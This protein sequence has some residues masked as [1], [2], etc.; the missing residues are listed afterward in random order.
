MGY[1]AIRHEFLEEALA[2]P[3]VLSEEEKAV[4]D[5]AIADMT[6]AGMKC[7]HADSYY[8]GSFVRGMLC[9]LNVVFFLLRPTIGHMMYEQ[10]IF[11]FLRVEQAIY[12]M[13]GKNIIGVVIKKF[14]GQK[15][16]TKFFA[17]LPFAK[18]GSMPTSAFVPE[19]GSKLLMN[20][21]SS[22]KM[23]KLNEIDE[24]FIK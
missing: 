9:C 19:H 10:I 17:S 23:M 20:N 4:N 5:E 3:T 15:F 16:C 13:F 6:A 2:R 24:F 8:F 21:G 12:I 11:A 14:V 7:V 1:A 18:A 22:P